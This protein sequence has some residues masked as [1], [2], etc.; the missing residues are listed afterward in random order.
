MT[1]AQIVTAMLVVA[2]ACGGESK[3]AGSVW[4]N[5]PVPPTAEQRFDRA[6]EE[7]CDDHE[8]E[9]AQAVERAEYARAEAAV[10][11]MRQG[12]CPRANHAHSGL[13]R[14]RLVGAWQTEGTDFE[15]LTL[16][17]DGTYAT[18][19]HARPFGAGTW[20]VEGDATTSPR[21]VLREGD[22]AVVTA[23]LGD[24]GDREATG[25]IDGSPV[26]WRRID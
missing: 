3:P 18:H 17:A 9:A 4:V 10:D 23:E 5:E 2:G 7:R 1:S 25:T 15:E 24:V 11:A 21:L 16:E 12:E 6:V 8:A 22:D 13:L 14:A 26:R 19:L 20:T